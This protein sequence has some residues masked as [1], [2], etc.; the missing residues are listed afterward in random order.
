MAQQSKSGGR[1]LALSVSTEQRP[2]F[3]APLV[4][5]VFDA[6]GTLTQRAD[7][8]GGKVQI[9]LPAES[10]QL[11]RVVIAPAIKNASDS[12]SPG[13]DR[14]LR[15]GAYEPVLRQ[16]GKLIDQIVVPGPIIDIWPFCF[17]WVRGRV[18]RASD[19][20]PVC[21]A[22][23]HICEVDRIPI[24]ILRLPDREIFRLRDDLFEVLRRPPIPIPEPGPDPAP[25]R[26]LA[27]AGARVGF[28]PQPD[29]PFARR[30]AIRFDDAISR[31]ALNPQPL[32]PVAKRAADPV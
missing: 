29:P 5:Y 8:A 30:A 18:V 24:W 17:C 11:P 26:R 21:H 12:D 2:D 25:W 9:D 6:S 13:I 15:L 32:P 16:A 27:G 20:R 1:R 28:D 19:N 31:V 14:L 7:I 23:V 3:K 10:A 4:A 22:R